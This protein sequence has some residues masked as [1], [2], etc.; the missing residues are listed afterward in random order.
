MIFVVG[1]VATAAQ[2]YWYKP[3][4]HFEQRSQWLDDATF[5][6]FISGFESLSSSSSSSSE[7]DDIDDKSDGSAF[8]ASVSFKL[9]PLIVTH[10]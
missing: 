10:K 2:L 1:I 6:T 8:D 4:L 5:G 7:D 3:H 9:K